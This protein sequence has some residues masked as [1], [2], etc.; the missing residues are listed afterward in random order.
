VEYNKQ[1]IYIYSIMA[2]SATKKAIV[3]LGLLWQFGEIR[4]EQRQGSK[5][6]GFFHEC[7]LKGCL[8]SE[9]VRGVRFMN[10]I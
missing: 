1:T 5:G 9:K 10:A 7:K 4:R 8:H 3:T 2:I 6:R